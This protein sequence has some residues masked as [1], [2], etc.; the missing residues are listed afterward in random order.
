M[1]SKVIT[2]LSVL[3]IIENMVKRKEKRIEN[4]RKP[5]EHGKMVCQQLPTLPE[6]YWQRKKE[7]ARKCCKKKERMTG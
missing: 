5:T 4:K 2:N 6:T 7:K 1:V 3:S